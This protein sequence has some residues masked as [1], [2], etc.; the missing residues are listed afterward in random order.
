MVM[1]KKW[2]STRTAGTALA[3][4]LACALGA[5]PASA[6]DPREAIAAKS[7]A[8]MKAAAA[9]QAAKPAEPPIQVRTSLDRTAMW[10]GDRVSYGVDVT[11]TK[12]VDILDDDLSKDKVK[13]D[14]L[15]LLNTEASTESGPHDTTIH[16]FRYTVTTYHVDQ[17]E[18]KIAP[19]T[20]RY[21]VKRPGQR[22]EDAAPAGEVQV[23]GAVIAYRSMLP[24]AQENYPLRDMPHPQP[25]RRRF[26]LA[27][28]LGL[29]LVVASIVPFGF[30]AAGAVRRR[31]QAAPHR[32]A[33]QVRQEEQTSLEALRAMDLS[34]ID[35]RREAYSRM[36]D[37][38]REHLRD[39]CGIA[40]QSLTPAEVEPALAAR[41]TAV[42][43]GTVTTLL[44]ACELARY[45]PAQALPSADQCRTAMDQAAEVLAA[46]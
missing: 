22:I 4:V 24:D 18:L 42:P 44:A 15:E 21:F 13:L 35:G 12:G 9:G 20:L 28:S 5:R 11:C 29:G 40:G 34:T 45:A 3:V 33:K 16:H 41:A 7:P 8:D 10:V 23:P 6:Q 32:S 2:E 36:N 26:A 46:R 14:G 38:V 31:A 1:A 27:Q 25:R 30:V 39:V 19:L 17:P 37:L 43:A